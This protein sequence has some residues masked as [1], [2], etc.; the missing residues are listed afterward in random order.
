LFKYLSE[1]YKKT[2]LKIEI[3]ARTR[4]KLKI[5]NEIILIKQASIIE[6]KII[7]VKGSCKFSKE[8]KL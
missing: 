2:G 1:R 7:S 8:E 6:E 3:I 4:H 5:K